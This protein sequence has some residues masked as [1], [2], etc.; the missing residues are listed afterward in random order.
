MKNK[1]KMVFSS[2]RCIGCHSCE[3]H[4][5]VKNEL[6]PGVSFFTLT[7][8]APEKVKGVPRV[9]FSRGIC[10][11][12]KKPDCVPACSE[13]AIEK[14]EKD[15]L[16]LIDESLCT[17]CKECVKACPYDNVFKWNQEKGIVYKCNFCEDRLG[18][19]LE[20]ACVAGCTTDALRLEIT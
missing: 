19:G 13:N 7:A 5:T 8:S 15:G 14:R 6:P 3:I 2:K 1:Y 17:G 16:V 9:T 11:H 4:C 12:C 20:P 18:A 10:R